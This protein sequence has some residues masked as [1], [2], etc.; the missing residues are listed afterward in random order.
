MLTELTNTHLG[1]DP[2]LTAVT[3]RTLNHDQWFI[4]GQVLS[5][6]SADSFSLQITVT[7]GTNTKPQIAAYIETVFAA[8]SELLGG[9]RDESY[10][11]VDEVPAASWGYGGKTQEYRFI[12]GRIELAA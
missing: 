6:P 2:A 10:I 11:V 9:I 8:M 1:K 12:A 3:I 7:E 5:G 4:G